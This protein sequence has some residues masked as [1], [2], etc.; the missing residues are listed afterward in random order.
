MHGWDKPVLHCAETYILF[1]ASEFS[2]CLCEAVHLRSGFWKAYPYPGC[3]SD[4]QDSL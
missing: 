4:L 1:A 2:Q 3:P